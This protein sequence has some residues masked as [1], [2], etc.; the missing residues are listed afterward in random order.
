MLATSVKT[1]LKEGMALLEANHI[2]DA[3][4]LWEN[5]IKL[6]IPNLN[7]DDQQKIITTWL[8]SLEKQYPL[9]INESET[10]ILVNSLKREFNDA[11]QIIKDELIKKIHTAKKNYYAHLLTS[12]NPTRRQLLEKAFTVL[13][14]IPQKSLSSS[15]LVFTGW[16]C[17]YLKL[18]ETKPDQRK[19]LFTFAWKY[20]KGGWKK[21]HS[22]RNIEL[23]LKALELHGWLIAD[24]RITHSFEVWWTHVEALGNYLRRIDTSIFDR[25]NPESKSI[26]YHWLAMHDYYQFFKT[27]GSYEWR[28]S[29]SYQI[30]SVKNLEHA[31]QYADTSKDTFLLGVTK[32]RLISKS[33]PGAV[34]WATYA[35]LD[36]QIQGVQDL[37]EAT[38]NNYLIA[39]GK[40][41]ASTY[42]FRSSW[43]EANRVLQIRRLRRSDSFLDEAIDILKHFSNGERL[44]YPY[45]R[46][47]FIATQL[48]KYVENESEKDQL[49]QEAKLYAEK[50]VESTSSSNNEAIK[51]DVHAALVNVWSSL[52]KS[53]DTNQEQI[54]NLDNVIQ[55]SQRRLELVDTKTQPR[56]WVLLSVDLGNL[57]I[58]KWNLDQKE[59]SLIIAKK[60]LTNALDLAIHIADDENQVHVHLLLALI[61]DY[62]TDYHSSSSHF[63]AAAKSLSEKKPLT[64]KCYL[65]WGYFE[66]GKEA[67]QSGE[68]SSAEQAFKEA[69]E[70]FKGNPAF[71]PLLFYSKG[72]MFLQQALQFLYSRK[73]QK[74]LASLEKTKLQFSY[75]KQS[76]QKIHMPQEFS[77]HYNLE[78]LVSQIRDRLNLCDVLSN[79]ET[80]KM[81]SLKNNHKRASRFLSNVQK[82]VGTIEQT[83]ENSKESL[84]LFND[85][86]SIWKTLEETWER[87]DHTSFVTAAED[88]E[89][90]LPKALDWKHATLLKANIAYLR[91]LG[92]LVHY[93]T[94]GITDNQEKLDE[95]LHLLKSAE[96]LFLKFDFI[97]SKWMTAMISLLDGYALLVELKSKD[98]IMKRPL[99]NAISMFRKS[100]DIFHEL[101]SREQ[102][103]QIT[104]LL[105]LLQKG[106][107]FTLDLWPLLSLP[108]DYWYYPL[109]TILVSNI[110]PI[111]LS[112]KEIEKRDYEVE[113]QEDTA[114]QYDHIA[115]KIVF[116][117]LI[118]EY[119]TDSLGLEIGE[120]AKGFRTLSQIMKATKL[121][122]I[123]IYGPIK[124]N[125]TQRLQ[126]IKVWPEDRPPPGEI[127]FELIEKGLIDLQFQSHS[128]G[129][130]GIIL[131]IRIAHQNPQIKVHIKDRLEGV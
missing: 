96:G 93:Q 87:K 8:S 131:K 121:S 10:L 122:S 4:S 61:S 103:K 130:G 94:S 60:Y 64:S 24:S 26:Y 55:I 92:S 23:Q 112:P 108:P 76:I 98:R 109:N 27:S 25:I 114:L 89:L 66:R 68:A 5:K 59:E 21:A 73:T 28:E 120:D 90:L 7:Q 62:T 15:D 99:N 58:D 47:S 65:G 116:D 115:S 69:S 104:V 45:R 14:K 84:V 40:I 13:K 32:G 57:L 19:S 106:E 101:R 80:A 88:L 85:F 113:V 46:K 110:H 53:Q 97:S 56:T 1:Q 44:A 2:E 67:I 128:R 63:I 41:W 86:I 83:Q 17:F 42:Y 129:R 43:Y 70:F 16:V 71:S 82:I 127:I 35:D 124:S 38:L 36:K 9:S 11:A 107:L 81:Y 75:A 3:I 111:L 91:A 72:M 39:L 118:Q 119:I 31:L 30:S 22:M 126:Q 34:G 105:R 29:H 77:D 20:A 78:P 48:A 49:V 51:L 79:F 33:R 102:G 117:Y 6:K 123:L 54:T 125:V 74:T 52:S 37:L 100:R 12:R 95:A 18:Y 50:A